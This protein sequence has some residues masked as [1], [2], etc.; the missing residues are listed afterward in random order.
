[1]GENVFRRLQEQ[2]DQYS[3]GFPASESGIEIELLKEMFTEEEAAM[4]TALTAELETPESV[5]G[6]LCRPIEEVADRL[7]DMAGKGLLFRTRQGTS[8]AYSAI[9]FI[10]GLLEFQID[11][12]DKD[13]K[14]IVKIAGRYINEK[15]KHNMAEGSDLFL[16]TVPVHRS[17]AAMSHVA[18]YEDARE[19]LRNEETIVLTDCAC[20]KQKSYF[21][22]DCGKPLEVCFM[23][24]P[25]G[26]YY[27][28]N[29]LGRKIDLKEAL[30][31]LEKAHDAGLI[32]QPAAAMK[33]FTMC[34][35][36]VDC[37]GFLR[38]ASKH[39]NPADLVFS[40]HVVRVDQNRCT[41]CETCLAR[42]G[43]G[44]VRMNADGVAETEPARCIGCGLCVSTCPEGAREL[45]PKPGGKHRTPP[46]DTP[47][48]MRA[49]AKKRGITRTDPSRIVSFGF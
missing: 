31:V 22:K 27:V 45:I 15:L 39:P 42:C 25:M 23:F 10:H 21:G 11:R 48:Q 20:R 13:V 49:M 4:F 30:D 36:C 38:A 40:N 18:P 33:P 14:K 7:E 5:A 26:E 12:S 32:T 37:C 28:E 1:M 24:G 47:S 35:C 34:N 19:I 46:A 9:P 16:R 3:I 8:T 17:I 2:L 29:G 6:R 41:G 44:A 43:M